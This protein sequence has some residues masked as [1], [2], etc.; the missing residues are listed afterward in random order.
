[1]LKRAESDLVNSVAIF[2]CK[3]VKGGNGNEQLKT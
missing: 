2:S 3:F 1:M